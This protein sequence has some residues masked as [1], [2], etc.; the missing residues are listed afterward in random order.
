MQ[1]PFGGK[2]LERSFDGINLKLASFNG[3]DP[4]FPFTIR[5]HGFDYN[6]VD[7]VP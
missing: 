5:A 6:G 4:I 2:I 7:C 3:T 1:Q